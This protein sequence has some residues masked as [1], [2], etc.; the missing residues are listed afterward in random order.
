MNQ[1]TAAELS[2]GFVYGSMAALTLAMFA[3]A[4]EL[5]FGTRS[6]VGRTVAALEP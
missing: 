4:A 6:R 3:Y 2:N 1:Q 5:A